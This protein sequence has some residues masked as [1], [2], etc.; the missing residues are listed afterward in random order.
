MSITG[1][2]DEQNLSN[3]LEEIVDWHLLGIKLGIPTFKLK[4]IEEDYKTNDQRKIETLA[5]WLQQ[6][7]RPS[8]SDVMSALRQMGEDAV[9]ESVQQQ[10]IGGDASKLMYMGV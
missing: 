1:K 2:L 4:K 3:V 5:T 6:T 7:P 9:A 10:Y 8:W